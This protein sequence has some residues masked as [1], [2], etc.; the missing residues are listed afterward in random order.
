MN[1]GHQPQHLQIQ[2]DPP[3]KIRG[4]AAWQRNPGRKRKGEAGGSH[5]KVYLQVCWSDRTQQLSLA[6]ALP[7]FRGR[8]GWGPAVASS[9][10]PSSDLN[11]E[12]ITD[13]DP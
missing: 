5:L 13:H 7:P 10:R 2:R 12:S 11:V 3:P 6:T 8:R 4:L 9:D 1:G